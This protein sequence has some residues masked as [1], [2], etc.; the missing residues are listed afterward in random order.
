MPQNAVVGCSPSR[1]EIKKRGLSGVGITVFKIRF[2]GL[3]LSDW[4]AMGACFRCDVCATARTRRRKIATHQNC[5]ID[6]HK[7]EKR[8]WISR[9]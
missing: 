1:A 4:L 6:G 2:D 8:I 5:Y 9:E 3:L 7:F